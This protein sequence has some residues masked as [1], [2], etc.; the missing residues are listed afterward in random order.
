[1]Y[2]YLN[3]MLIVLVFVGNILYTQK[4][5]AADSAELTIE[6]VKNMV[7]KEGQIVLLD[8]RTEGEYDGHLGH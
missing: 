6:Q 1:M 4:S 7:N 3:Y 8:V 2:K 5:E